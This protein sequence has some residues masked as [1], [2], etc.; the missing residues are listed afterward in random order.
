MQG[1]QICAFI[2]VDGSLQAPAQRSQA[3]LIRPIVQI[4]ISQLIQVH[5]PPLIPGSLTWLDRR[6]LHCLTAKCC[7]LSCCNTFAA[8]SMRTGNAEEI[9]LA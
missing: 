7:A 2:G 5:P 9:L 1:G 3:A 6:A 8:S 4:S